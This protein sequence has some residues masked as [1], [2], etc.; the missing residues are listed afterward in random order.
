MAC[1]SRTKSS[2][3]AIDTVQIVNKILSD[4]NVTKDLIPMKDTIYIFKTRSV[5]C[6][7]PIK[8]G[9]FNVMYIEPGKKNEDLIDLS[10]SSFYDKRTKID[11]GKFAIR[12]DSAK[13][14]I[15][16]Y[17]YQNVLIYDFELVRKDNNWA[18]LNTIN[19]T[20]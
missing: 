13:V 4:R 16:L 9:S 20:H 10:P 6:N 14:S 18:I 5:N 12:N 2:S 7:W 11:F 15:G 17:K 8:T 19:K 1:Q 3:S